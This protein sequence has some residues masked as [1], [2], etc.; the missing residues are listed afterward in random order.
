[1]RAATLLWELSNGDVWQLT[2]TDVTELGTE[3]LY[4]ITNETAKSRVH[5]SRTYREAKELLLYMRATVV[6]EIKE[7]V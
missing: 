3:S 1:M 4:T 5:V 6:T 2:P 7:E